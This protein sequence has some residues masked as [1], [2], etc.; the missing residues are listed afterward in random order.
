MKNKIIP[1]VGVV[2]LILFMGGCARL[3]YDIEPGSGGA[4][5]RVYHSM[6]IKVNVR[7][8][9][10]REKGSFKILLK[11][12]ETRDKMLF[13]SPVN[14]VYGILIVEGEEAV[15]VNTKK[16]RYWEGP[17]NDLLQELW[18]MDFEYVEFKRLLVEGAPPEEKLKEK[19]IEVMIE[20]GEEGKAPER[21]QV[22][23]REMQVRIKI[24]DRQEGKG[25]IRFALDTKGM[26]RTTIR[27]L[28]E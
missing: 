21:M 14:Q 2:V 17:F 13:L 27:E 1:A 4:G 10:T 15:L 18:G 8:K 20:K 11:Y 19:G 16:K 23:T 28:L 7:N 24:T 5:G 12:D 3:P 22:E 26:K 25:V 9:E 6:G